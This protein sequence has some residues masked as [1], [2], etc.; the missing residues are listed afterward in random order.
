MFGHLSCSHQQIG[1]A[2][3][4]KCLQLD[5]E[6]YLRSPAP[7]SNKAKR[8]A[9][10]VT[11][12]MM[13][14]VLLMRIANVTEHLRMLFNGELVEVRRGIT[15]RCFQDL[16]GRQGHNLALTVLCVPCSLDSGRFPCGQQQ[17]QMRCGAGPRRDDGR[18]TVDA[19]S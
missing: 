16:P 4:G 6:V 11:G 15:L 3:F 12:E 13:V 5:G 19:R 17:G 10:L 18:G 7:R 2:I 9:A 1:G 14:E 8:D